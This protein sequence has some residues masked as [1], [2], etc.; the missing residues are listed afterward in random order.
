MGTHDGPGI[1]QFKPCVISPKPHRAPRRWHGDMPLSHSLL[2]KELGYDPRWS[3]NAVPTVIHR[4]A[5]NEQPGHKSA[6]PDGPH[7]DL[8]TGWGARSLESGPGTRAVLG[9]PGPP[10]GLPPPCTP[11]PSSQGR[12]HFGRSREL[13]PPAAETGAD[14]ARP[15][16]PATARS[17]TPGFWPG[18]W[19]G[20][21]FQS[22]TLGNSCLV[23]VI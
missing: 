20:F 14:P 15:P 16:P 18:F 1:V 4:R 10:R 5:P 8:G 19:P 13:L 12:S 23:R 9:T 11:T 2:A 6:G 21:R 17:G 3:G 22:H 7:W